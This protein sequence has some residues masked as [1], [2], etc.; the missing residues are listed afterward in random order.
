M[1]WLHL[2]ITLSGLRNS[3]FIVSMPISAFLITLTKS[4][5]AEGGVLGVYSTRGLSTFTA[6]EGLPLTPLTHRTFGEEEEV[7]RRDKSGELIVHDMMSF[8]SDLYTKSESAHGQNDDEGA[9]GTEEGGDEE[10]E[11]GMGVESAR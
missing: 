7:M 5:S 10:E 1:P 3:A 9:D 8:L 11:E 6:N 4:L 2:T